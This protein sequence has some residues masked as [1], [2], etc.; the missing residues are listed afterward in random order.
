MDRGLAVVLTA[1]ACGLIAAQA[2]INAELGRATGSMAAALARGWGEPVLATDSGSG[3]AAALA[4]E[5]G[6]AAIESTAA[7]AE[8]AD[9]HVTGVREH[10]FDPVPA[11]ELEVLG[12]ALGRVAEHLREVRAAPRP[13]TP[14]RAATP[15]SSSSWPGWGR[16]TR[17]ACRRQSATW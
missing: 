2:P 15:S 6:G 17:T 11:D 14:A 9:V 16:A 3:S 10:L 13:G 5:L 1:V 12:R 7:L 4:A 8:R